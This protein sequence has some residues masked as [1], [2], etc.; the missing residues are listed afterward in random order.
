MACNFVSLADELVKVGYKE[1]IDS[2]DM[3]EAC[4]STHLFG[5]ASSEKK[6]MIVPVEDPKQFQKT[7][8]SPLSPMSSRL[9]CNKTILVNF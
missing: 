6:G 9:M 7:K 4:I 3:S 5:F 1:K 8:L 2:S